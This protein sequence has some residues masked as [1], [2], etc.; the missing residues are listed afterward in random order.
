MIEGPTLM[1][2]VVG[3]EGRYLVHRDGQVFNRLANVMAVR[4]D[5]YG[6]ANVRLNG[7][8]K[9]SW[10]KVARLVAEA[11][12]GPAPDAQSHAAHLNGDPLNNCVENIA[13]KT[14]KANNADK[15]LHG[16]HQAGEK[17]PRVKLSVAQVETIRASTLA[18]RAL[19]AQYGVNQSQI[20]R[21]KNGARWAA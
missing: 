16:T 5:R 14:P 10:K 13:W 11:W 7:G 1:R 21:I 3:Y 19:A 2:W 9:Q 17:H 6:Y 15:L 8:G 20:V 18:S 4:I 12:H